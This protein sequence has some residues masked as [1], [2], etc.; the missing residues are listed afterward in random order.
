M[1]D[2]TW[3]WL[4]G[5]ILWMAIRTGVLEDGSSVR[6]LADVTF[7]HS[8]WFLFFITITVFQDSSPM[9]WSKSV[10]EDQGLF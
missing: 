2:V 10:G 6:S 5:L 1:E 4:Y 3:F 7:L 9:S 8:P